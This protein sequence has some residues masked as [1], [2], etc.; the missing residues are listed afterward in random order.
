T[1]HFAEA[2]VAAQDAHVPAFGDHFPARRIDQLAHDDSDGTATRSLVG[3]RMHAVARDQLTSRWQR[4]AD[5][6]MLF[7]VNQPDR[8]RARPRITPP[9]AG[10]AEDACHR[11]YR[12]EVLFIDVSELTRVK[13]IHTEAD[14]Q[15]VEHRVARGVGASDVLEAPGLHHPIVDHLPLP[16]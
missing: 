13:G 15:G 8:I 5:A 2:A 9:D 3:E 7:G 12:L 16:A 10:R 14:G 1:A 4:L 6:Q 11:G